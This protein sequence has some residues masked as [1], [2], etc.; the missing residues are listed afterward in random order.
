MGNPGQDSCVD[1][2]SWTRKA[3]AGWYQEIASGWNRGMLR[4]R[5]K[6]IQ[7][8]FCSSIWPNLILCFRVIKYNFLEDEEQNSCPC[9]SNGYSNWNP[10]QKHTNIQC[11][12]HSSKVLVISKPQRPVPRVLV[13]SLPLS[14]LYHFSSFIASSPE[15]W[16]QQRHLVSCYHW[17]HPH[18]KWCVV[19]TAL[20]IL[21]KEIAVIRKL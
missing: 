8:V 14:F 2:Y 17:R 10:V 15:N 6:P 21:L 13:H 11:Q 16:T 1:S 7:V 20:T 5:V 18:Q 9:C 4:G 19:S 3:Q 12:T